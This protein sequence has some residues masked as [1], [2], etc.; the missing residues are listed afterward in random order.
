LVRTYTSGNQHA[1][2][3]SD[4]K[5]GGKKEALA[6]ARR[7]L[8]SLPKPEPKP[9]IPRPTKRNTTGVNGVG[10]SYVMTSSGEKLECFVVHYKNEEGERRMKR[11]Y[12]HHYADD[13]SALQDA[14]EFRRQVEEQILR[15]W[16]ASL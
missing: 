14:A 8:R 12:L 1:R 16:R 3:F 10:R 7:Y 6:T 5:H 9:P 4:R 11:F 2:F 13:K 15:E